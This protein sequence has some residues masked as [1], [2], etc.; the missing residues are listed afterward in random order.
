MASCDW[1]VGWTNWALPDT[2][3][4]EATLQKGTAMDLDDLLDRSAPPTAVRT[5]ALERELTA[6]VLATESAGRPRPKAL[7]TAWVGA[8]ATGLVGVGTAGAMAAGLVPTP[9]WVPWSTSSGTNCEMRFYANPAGPD[10]EPLNG[11]YS[12]A[13]KGRAVA[14]ASIFLAGFDYDSID[15]AEAIK[16]WQ[17]E[18]A[19]TI[20]S[21]TD[22]AERQ[23]PLT[24]DELEITAVGAEVWDHLAA[25]LQAEG[26]PAELV[27][28]GQGWRCNG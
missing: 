19:A 5:P 6:L 22:P 14:E 26:T 27:V 13:E 17:Q 23:P 25:H 10:G 28:F 12:D 21:V 8:L 16:K 11:T 1:T 20:A 2:Y 9:S 4:V 24:G 3:G 7:R 18:E 15:E